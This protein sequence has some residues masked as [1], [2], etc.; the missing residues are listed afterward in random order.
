MT[1][2]F[3]TFLLLIFCSIGCTP[4][5]FT[6]LPSTQGENLC[7]YIQ[8]DNILSSSHIPALFWCCKD[9]CKEVIFMDRT[10][11]MSSQA[12]LV[13]KRDFLASVPKATDCK[14]SL[15]CKIDGKCSSKAG[16]CK[17][18]SDEDCAQSRVC[19]SQGK[20]KAN[21]G[22]CNTRAQTTSP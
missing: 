2:S 12:R 15:D 6:A 21:S 11:I 3:F 4:K 8:R 1:N 5:S 14:T 17:A 20:C 19:K 18:L 7:T 16:V 13:R 10:Q 22:I 9:T